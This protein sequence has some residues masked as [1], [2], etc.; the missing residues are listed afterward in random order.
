M[1]GHGGYIIPF[2]LPK[3]LS[4]SQGIV[5]QSNQLNGLQDGCGTSG[6]VL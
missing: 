2:S 5:H 3:L 4:L 1:Q 6:D